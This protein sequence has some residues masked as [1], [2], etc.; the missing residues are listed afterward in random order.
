M[1]GLNEGTWSI[2]N[3][4]CVVGRSWAT[5]SYF[6]QCSSLLETPDYYYIWGSMMWSRWSFNS[7]GHW[8]SWPFRKNIYITLDSY[9]TLCLDTTFSLNW[10]HWCKNKN[11]RSIWK[12]VRG[13]L[14]NFKEMRAFLD[15]TQVQE[16]IKEK[17]DILNTR[18]F[19]KILYGNGQH[20]RQ[21]GRRYLQTHSTAKS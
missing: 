9:R 1:W 4:V 20:K 3:S 14:W 6:C 13:Y 19:F 12:G 21:T 8:D 16:V 11:H 10:D 2:Y 7:V 15:I 5:R 18:H 17:T